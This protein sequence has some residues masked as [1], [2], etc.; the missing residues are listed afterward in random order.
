MLKWERVLFLMG[1]DGEEINYIL[2]NKEKEISADQLFSI[3]NGSLVMRIFPN[4]NDEEKDL[5]LSVNPKYFIN[6]I[7]FMF[8]YSSDSQK[9]KIIEIIKGLRED[10]KVDNFS[11]KARVIID[12]FGYGNSS[13]E[14]KLLEI[15]GDMDN[16]D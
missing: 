15:I 13:D 9:S 4:L 10:D 11:T 8:H 2:T 1:V 16:L 3:G 5:L 12:V 7:H 6:N 14:D